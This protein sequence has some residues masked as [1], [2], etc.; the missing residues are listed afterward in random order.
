MA[1]KSFVDSVSRTAPE[2]YMIGTNS[3]QHI[4]LLNATH[5]RWKLHMITFQKCCS[6]AQMDRNTSMVLCLIYSTPWFEHTLN[7]VLQ[8]HATIQR[9]CPR[10][11]AHAAPKRVGES[12][13]FPF[14]WLF[15]DSLCSGLFS[16]QRFCLYNFTQNECQVLL[17]Q[18]SAS[19]TVT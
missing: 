12:L 10:L 3:K 9:T 19:V 8:L 14:L 4:V 5:M 1:A 16:S 18:N 13:F 2:I 7:I 11:R 6:W 15:S 17:A